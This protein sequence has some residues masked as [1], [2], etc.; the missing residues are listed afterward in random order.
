MR[1]RK[2]NKH[3]CKVFKMSKKKRSEMAQ[4][5]SEDLKRGDAPP[6][7]EG[8]FFYRYTRNRTE[9]WVTLDE[10]NERRKSKINHKHSQSKQAKTE[11]SKKHTI[12]T[13]ELQ[14][15]AKE[16]LEKLRLAMEEKMQQLRNTERV[17]ED[18]PVMSFSE[19]VAAQK[20][21]AVAVTQ[22]DLNKE[23]R[24]AKNAPFS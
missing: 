17:P 9:S 5:K 12:D 15:L 14:L 7:I 3:F 19:M 22:A 8:L 23:S 11:V 16:N 21:K 4:T 1:L 13:V 18:V 10:L 6:T 20:A 24:F 2:Q